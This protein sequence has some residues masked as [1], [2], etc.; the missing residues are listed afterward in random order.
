M[1]VSFNPGNLKTELQ[2]H[3]Q[4]MMARLSESMLYPAIFG[5]YTELYS[6]WSG[7]VGK[8]A[9]Y[10][11]PWGRQG[12]VYVRKDILTGLKNGQADRFVKWCESETLAFA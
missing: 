7:E 9:L 11:I 3:S 12:A 1:S 2:R 6:G 8:D 5:A 10:V 4:G